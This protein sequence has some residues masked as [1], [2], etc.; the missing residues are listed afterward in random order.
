MT[1]DPWVVVGGIGTIILIV[2]TAVSLFRRAVRPDLRYQLVSIDFLI[3]PEEAA[4]LGAALDVRIGGTP[5]QTTPAIRSYVLRITNFGGARI[6]RYD[7]P[8]VIDFGTQAKR[9][10][11]VT[12]PT[13][14]PGTF[15]VPDPTLHETSVELGTVA[16]NSHDGIRVRCLVESDDRIKP[17]VRARGDGFS[18]VREIPTSQPF[19]FWAV[20][21]ATLGILAVPAVVVYFLPSRQHV[22]LLV[23]LLIIFSVFV[24]L[25]LNV[26]L[27]SAGQYIIFP[28]IKSRWQAFRDRRRREAVR[29]RP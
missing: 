6:E 4:E 27:V 9:V 22:P 21:L 7:D 3:S 11:T 29:R 14:F 8:I 24:F 12:K 13:T 5:V 1:S 23:Y 15:M 19:S 10:W 2:L 17:V 25:I 26:L 28:P 18:I 16:L 20:F